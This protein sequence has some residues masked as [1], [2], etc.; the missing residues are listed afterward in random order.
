MECLDNIK[1]FLQTTFAHW[2]YQKFLKHNKFAT[3]KVQC[4]HAKSEGCVSSSLEMH[5]QVV[6]FDCVRGVFVGN[7]VQNLIQKQL[8][9]GLLSQTSWCTLE[10]YTTLQQDS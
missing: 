4:S 9:Q 8:P 2:S 10:M 7:R 5:V 6:R 3:S 1:T